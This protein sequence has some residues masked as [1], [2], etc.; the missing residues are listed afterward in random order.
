M[1]QPFI[2][3][4]EDGQT[5]EAWIAAVN[6]FIKDN[7]VK[8]PERGMIALNRLSLPVRAC[9]RR[10]SGPLE[11]IT[12]KPWD[13]SWVRLQVA[14]LR[15]ED[16]I[17]QAKEDQIKEA[18]ADIAKSAT[19]NL[20]FPALFTLALGFMGFSGSGPVKHSFAANMQ[21]SFGNV[22]SGSSFARCQQFAMRASN[23]STWVE[24]VGTTA[25]DS[26]VSVANSSPSASWDDGER[27]R[28][29]IEV[30]EMLVNL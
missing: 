18:V 6:T 28:P 5:V 9:I 4:G 10:C 8:E 16:Q 19:K 17:R 20:L 14:L 24:R 13:W 21:S 26:L 7:N 3:G 2:F 27:F 1:T 25:A 11:A 22:R 23:I 12:G 15:I 30:I 29:S